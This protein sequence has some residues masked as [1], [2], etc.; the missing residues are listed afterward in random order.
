MFLW[1]MLR[2]ARVG[3]AEPEHLAATAV[4]VRATLSEH[5]DADVA[6]ADELYKRLDVFASVGRLNCTI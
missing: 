5:L 1:Q 4:S 3:S 2:L 6:L